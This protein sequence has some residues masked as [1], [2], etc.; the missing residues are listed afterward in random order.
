MYI[1]GKAEKIPHTHLPQVA[2]S[3]F[4]AKVNVLTFGKLQDNFFLFST[5][6]SSIQWLQHKT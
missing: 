6:F 1:N 3:G 2:Q 5:F 4:N